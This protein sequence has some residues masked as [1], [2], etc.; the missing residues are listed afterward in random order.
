MKIHVDTVKLNTLLASKG[1]NANTFSQATGLPFTTMYR[2][3]RGTHAVSPRIAKAIAE[4]L[5]VQFEYLFRVGV[6]S[7]KM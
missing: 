6:P 4:G 1:L 3:C 5:G 2:I 7:E